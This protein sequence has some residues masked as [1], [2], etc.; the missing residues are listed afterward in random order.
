MPKPKW[1]TKPQSN[2]LTA[3]LGDFV[4]AQEKNLPTMTHF[5]LA[6]FML[7]GSRHSR[8]QIRHQSS[9][10]IPKAKWM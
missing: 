7:I 1:T 8:A 6:L 5:F 3:H 10:Q 9:S 2:W 4:A